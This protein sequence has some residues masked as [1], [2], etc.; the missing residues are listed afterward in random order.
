M[1]SP[2]NEIA[3]SYLECISIGNRLETGGIV[4]LQQYRQADGQ[5]PLVG[6]RDVVGSGSWNWASDAFIRNKHSLHRHF[7]S[8]PV[9]GHTAK[10][11]KT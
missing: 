10:V 7:T 8:C 11:L 4:N 5:R 2:I 9:V 6:D 1:I 3:A